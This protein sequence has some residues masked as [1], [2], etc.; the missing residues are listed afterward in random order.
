VITWLPVTR[1]LVGASVVLSMAAAVYIKGRVDGGARSKESYNV[2]KSQNAATQAAA[3]EVKKQRDQSV[4]LAEKTLQDQRKTLEAANELQT[5]LDQA[6]RALVRERNVSIA[7]LRDAATAVRSA[8]T[9]ELAATER[10]IE[11][12]NSW[13]ESALSCERLAGQGASVLVDTLSAF[14]A[15]QESRQEAARAALAAR[16]EY[17]QLEEAVIYSGCAERSN[18]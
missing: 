15:E 7:R 6:E 8:T 3:A 12:A 18:Q 4:V 5:K 14:T 2:L 13:R 11:A 1:W 17:T 10:S 9:A 16:K